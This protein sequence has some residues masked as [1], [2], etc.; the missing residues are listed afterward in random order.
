MFECFAESGPDEGPFTSVHLNQSRSV[1]PLLTAI[2]EL[3]I[4]HLQTGLSIAVMMNR[5]GRRLK[6]SRNIFVIYLT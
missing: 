6:G 2:F 3:Y 4:F 5:I 1:T